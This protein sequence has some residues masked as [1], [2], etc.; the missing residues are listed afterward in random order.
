MICIGGVLLESF[1]FIVFFIF[2]GFFY[3]FFYVKDGLGRFRF[4]GKFVK[5]FVFEV[6]VSFL[7]FIVI[8][9]FNLSVF[10]FGKSL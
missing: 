2:V 9:V 8:F 1:V 3:F 5:G 6:L 10:F 7:L 4:I